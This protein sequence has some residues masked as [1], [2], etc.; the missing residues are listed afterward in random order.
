M[1][2]Y[3]IRLTLQAT[4]GVL[5]CTGILPYIPRVDDIIGWPASV[6][7]QHFSF[8]VTSSFWVTE[9]VKKNTGYV[10]MWAHNPLPTESLIKLLPPIGW[11]ITATQTTPAV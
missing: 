4:D 7:G 5:L 11:V 1:H 3:P 8:T 2:K 10:A 9:S 6:V